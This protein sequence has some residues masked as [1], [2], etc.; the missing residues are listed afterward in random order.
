MA[1]GRNGWDM[2]EPGEYV[3]QAAL[4]LGEEDIVSNPLFIR[5][6]PPATEVEEQLAQSYFSDEVGRTL[7][8]GGSIA[9]TAAVDTLQAVADQL[10]DS[11][12]ALHAR[13]AIGG[14]LARSYK[15]L[16]LDA[17]V[18]G[19]TSAAE[20]GGKIVTSRAK[21]DEAVREISAA[22][23][24]KPDVAAETFG[25]VEFHDTVDQF[26]EFLDDNGSPSEAAEAQ[27][28]M[29]KTLEN[30]GVLDSVLSEIDDKRAAYD[31]KSSKK[32]STKSTK[33]PST[34][35]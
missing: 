5:V 32:A 23:L 4:H 20:V 19:L 24:T 34:K 30:R 29:H 26:S 10:P 27:A 33:K 18:H 25:H 31:A 35:K 15:R 7:A 9:L 12:A 16:E 17:G 3:L 22:L 8:F 11:R 14:P 21:V 13:L 1:A 28:T 2:A 6:S